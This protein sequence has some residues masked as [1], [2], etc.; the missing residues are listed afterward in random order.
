VSVYKH[1]D[2]VDLHP[3]GTATVT[4]RPHNRRVI[5]VSAIGWSVFEGPH[6]TLLGCGYADRDAA[7][8]SLIGDPAVTA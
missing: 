6:M 8:R 1:D 2:R 5:E 7:I 3:D 4:G